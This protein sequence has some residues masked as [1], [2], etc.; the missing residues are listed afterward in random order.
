MIVNPSPV[1]QKKIKSKENNV[2]DHDN[3]RIF[4]RIGRRE[5]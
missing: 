2:D 5:T 1:N 4:N 3:R